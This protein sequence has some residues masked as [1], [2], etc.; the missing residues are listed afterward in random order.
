MS[1]DLENLKRWVAGKTPLGAP[2]T[3]LPKVPVADNTE[4]VAQPFYFNVSPTEAKGVELF[5]NPANH[6][7]AAAT[8]MTY[9]GTKAK[10]IPALGLKDQA[11]QFNDYLTRIGT[12][13][14]FVTV[15]SEETGQ[16]VTSQDV[17]I[18]IDQIKAAYTGFA[19]ADLNGIVDSVQK[20]ANSIL[21]KSSKESDKA[22]FSQDTIY[23]EDHNNYITIFYAHLDMKETTSGKKTYI[24]QTYRIFR[25]VIR[26]NTTYLVTF[27]EELAAM[28]GDG[29]LD[30]W[31]TQGSSPTGDKLSCFQTNFKKTPK[32]V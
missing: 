7:D 2:R 22:V 29:G 5:R 13:P 30:E 18:M 14:G 23:K 24:E 26:V 10:F 31:D 25:T 32:E 3:P 27:A 8:V 19:T 15:K 6:A 20:M 1:D 4:M 21:N 16:N 9:S 12:F 28:L 17:N 11:A